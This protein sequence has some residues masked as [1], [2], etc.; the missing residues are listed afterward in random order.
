MKIRCANSGCRKYQ[1]KESSLPFGR[2]QFVCSQDCRGELIAFLNNKAQDR[3]KKRK[4]IPA[5]IRLQ[6]TERDGQRCRFCGGTN[7]LHAHHILYRSEGAGHNERNLV[8]LCE[9]D[10]SRVHSRKRYWQPILLELIEIQYNQGLYLMVPQ[11][12][13]LVL[14]RTE[15]RSATAAMKAV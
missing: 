5:K 8:T 11:V 4:D 13:D 10:H 9:A 6:V 1:D 7:R 12:E 2:M 3:S 14:R 15:E